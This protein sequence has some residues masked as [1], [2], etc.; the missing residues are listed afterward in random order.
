MTHGSIYGC[1]DIAI[2]GPVVTECIQRIQYSAMQAVIHNL[3]WLKKSHGTQHNA[4]LNHENM[5]VGHGMRGDM[6]KAC[7]SQEAAHKR[8]VSCTGMLARQRDTHLVEELKLF[9]V[10]QLLGGVTRLQQRTGRARLCIQ[11]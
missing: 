8:L 1:K 5:R 11:A 10:G 3:R 9:V 2:I 4:R 6:D 7:H